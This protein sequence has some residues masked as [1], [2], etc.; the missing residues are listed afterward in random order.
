MLYF[1]RWQAILIVLSSFAAFLFAAPN[2]LPK[3]VL[4]AMPSWMPLKQMA[5]GLD[6]QGGSH[7]L[8]QMN[9]EELR[10]NWL[11]TVQGDVRKELRGERDTSGKAERLGY[12]AVTTQ[13]GAVRVALRDP[14]DMDKVLKR[15]KTLS[16]PIS[17]SI[18]GGASGRDLDVEADGT[19]AV[20]LR[21]TDAALTAKIGA[22][23]EL[24]AGDHPPPYRRAGHHRAGH[25]APGARPHSG[26][27]AGLR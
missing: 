1:P 8:L 16:Q 25:S 2:V 14:A 12:G 4:Q 21:P 9:A 5:L 23:L 18:L 11:R 3:S 6:L 7:I 19:T 20:L 17:T 24:F 26:A 15:L 22:A 10:Q 13:N 27:G